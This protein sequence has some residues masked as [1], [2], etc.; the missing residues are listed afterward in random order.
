MNKHQLVREHLIKNGS[1]TSWEAIQ[2][3]GATRLSAII[4]NLR[5]NGMDIRTI[6]REETDRYGNTTQYAN[7][8]Y[9]G[10]NK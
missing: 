10:E 2:N 7:Y 8:V 1:I 3:Y 9:K 5:K 4:F 6:M